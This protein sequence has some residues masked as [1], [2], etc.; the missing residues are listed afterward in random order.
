MPGFATHYLFGVDA[1]RNLT[2]T[3]IRNNLKQNHSAYALG[4]QGPDLFFYYLPSYL[5]HRQNIGALAHSQDTRAFFTYLLESRKLF[6]GN[7]AKQ[8]IAD[9]YILGFLGHYTLD[10]A[11][12]PYVYAFTGYTPQTPPGNLKYFGQHAYFETEIDN[13]LLYRKKHIL[14]SQFHQSGTIRLTALQKRVIVRMLVYAYR[15]TYPGL[16][17]S[18]ILLG[19]APMWMKLGT[20]LFHDPSGQKKVLVRLLE[21]I[22]VGRA[23]LS[24]MLPSDHYR[25]IAD[26]LNERHRTW[27]HPWTGTAS[28]FSFD[29]LYQQAGGHYMKRIEAYED[30]RCLNFSKNATDV[31]LNEYGN[32]SFLSGQP[33]C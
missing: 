29:E 8:D 27:I 24:P 31:F 26:P 7:R 20:R 25:F 33:C 18:E 2:S 32:L 15:N 28:R 22:L 12:H 17:A 11:I 30:L 21:R 13:V 23:F 10:C 5:M 9:A 14:P 3:R 4:L 16:L 6:E 1:Y 19:G